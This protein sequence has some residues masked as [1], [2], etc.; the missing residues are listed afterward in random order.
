[1]TKQATVLGA[2]G[3]MGK[4]LVP[5]LIGRGYHVKAAGRLSPNYTGDRVSNIA[6][7]YSDTKSIAQA[8]QGSAHTYVV[9]GFEYKTKVW[10]EEWPPL[11]KRLIE[12]A[13]VSK[14]KLIFFDNVYSYG[15]VDGPM[16][17]G[18]PSKPN[19]RKGLVRAEVDNLLLDAI[20]QGRAN[21]VIA[22]SA[23]FYGPDMPVSIIG[24]R[25]FTNI[26]TKQTFEWMGKMDVAHSFTYIIDIVQALILLAESDKT[27]G[28]IYHLP[29]SSPAL[30]GQQIQG[31][32]SQELGIPLK[33]SLISRGLTYLLQLFVPILSE[34]REMMYQNEHPY[35]FDS[36]KITHQFPELKP[37]SYQ[38]GL[39]ETLKWYQSNTIAK[40]KESI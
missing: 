18:T 6:V 15:L 32:L 13:I 4:L 22:K 9:I 35:I 17:E 16:T 29:T 23:D 26:L 37:T 5:A 1:M 36:S 27:S 34:V 31:L 40:I 21:I 19:T 28:E 12:A 8:M 39:T 11:T 24:D 25:F 30:T 20:A 7:D 33:T 3:N 10:Q 14:T 2:S 38:Q